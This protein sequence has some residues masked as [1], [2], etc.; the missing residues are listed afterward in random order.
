MDEKSLLRAIYFGA[1]VRAL[2]SQLFLR[3]LFVGE[4]KLTAN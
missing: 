3:M 1:T 2:T 4:E